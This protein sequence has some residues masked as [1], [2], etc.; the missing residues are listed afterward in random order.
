MVLQGTTDHRG[1]FINVEV[2]WSGKNHDAYIFTNSALCEM[3]D[4]EAFVPNHP[5]IRMSSQQIPPLI[6]GDCAYLLCPWLM[7]PYG[8]A[9][10][11]QQAH[12]NRCHT[13]ARIVVEQAFGRL[14]GRWRAIGARLEMAEENVPSIVSACCIL[15]NICESR[16]HALEGEIPPHNEIKLATLGAPLV[17]V[18]NKHSQQGRDMRDAVAKYQWRRRR[19]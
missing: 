17:N 1:R 5:T 9:T 15:H 13:R 10:T 14:K 3:M 4:A 7:R 11:P 6:L 19:C 16:G 8:G 2:G 18:D 12:F